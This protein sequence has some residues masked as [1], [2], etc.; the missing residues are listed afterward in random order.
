MT[1]RKQ[2]MA[3]RR[4]NVAHPTGTVGSRQIAIPQTTLE[5]MVDASVRPVQGQAATLPTGLV[6]P[7]HA[8]RNPAVAVAMAA[9]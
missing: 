9:R 5:P 3:T 7:R 2:L 1:G 4:D 6:V 8:A